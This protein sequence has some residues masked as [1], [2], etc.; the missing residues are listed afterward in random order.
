MTL[1][2]WLCRKSVPFAPPVPHPACDP[3]K[4]RG[5]QR[6]QERRE[7]REEAQGTRE[8]RADRGEDMHTHFSL[9]LFSRS[10]SLLTLTLTRA[11]DPT[12]IPGS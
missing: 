12:T 3:N 1:P 11:A 10:L 2:L 8:E 6:R 9:S 4:E 7:W 5:E